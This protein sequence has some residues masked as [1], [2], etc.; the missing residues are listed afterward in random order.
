MLNLPATP[1]TIRG[2]RSAQHRCRPPAALSSLSIFSSNEIFENAAENDLQ[3]CSS[4]SSSTLHEL[5]ETS[6][7][8]DAFVESAPSRFDTVLNELAED[9]EEV[10]ERLLNHSMC[11][12]Y[13]PATLKKHRWVLRCSVRLFSISPAELKF[14]HIHAS[15]NSP[16]F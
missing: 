14:I 8:D 5:R 4:S 12:Q 3:P 7:F 16:N 6:P 11:P 1:P 15:P 9:P 13:S 2:A 10:Q